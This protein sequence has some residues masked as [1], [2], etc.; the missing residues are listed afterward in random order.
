MPRAGVSGSFL[1][2]TTKQRIHTVLQAQRRAFFHMARDGKVQTAHDALSAIL[3]ASALAAADQLDLRNVFD[4][5]GLILEMQQEVAVDVEVNHPTLAQRKEFADFRKHVEILKGLMGERRFTADALQNMCAYQQKAGEIVA[6]V[7]AGGPPVQLDEEPRPGVPAQKKA[8]TMDWEAVK[9]LA[10]QDLPTEMDVDGQT[11][12]R[13][14][15]ID[16]M[17]KDSEEKH[18]LA[19]NDAKDSYRSRQKLKYP[20]GTVIEDVGRAHVGGYAQFNV[21]GLKPGKPLAV[22][23]R[24]DYV[25]GDYEIEFFVDGKNAGVCSCAGT[26]RVHRWRNW[27]YVIAGRA[28]HQGQGHASS[29]TPAPPVA[30]SICSDIGST[31]RND[32]DSADSMF[33]DPLIK[34]LKAPF[35]FRKEKVFG[36]IS[37]KGGLKGDINRLKDVGSSTSR[38][39]QAATARPR[40]GAARETD[41]EGENGTLLEE[42]EMPLLRREAARELGPVPVLRLVGGAGRAGRGRRHRRGGGGGGKMR[43]MAIDMGGGGG[44]ACKAPASAGWCRSTGRRRASCSSSRA[45]RSSAPR[46]TATRS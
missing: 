29:R 38:R 3:S 42:E 5:M 13:V 14:D 15:M 8:G 6:S 33:L 26:D 11:W 31:S 46:A 40:A 36:S 2:T 32:K 1:D 12:V 7:F 37:S 9:A 21:S 19:I 10:Q 23:R 16:V 41:K 39:R 35:D 43:T 45:A 4:V 17:D 20:D 18:A 22:V 24:M 25:Y 27:P 34:A 30:T 28:H 44:G